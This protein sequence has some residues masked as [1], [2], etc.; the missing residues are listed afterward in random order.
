MAFAL[1]RTLVRAG[2]TERNATLGTLALV[3]SPMYLM[4]SATFMSD[5]TG[6]FGIVICLYGCLRA[7][8]S[9]TD[10]STLAW[11]GFAVLTNA[12]FGSSRQIAWLGILVMLPSTL[13]L[14]RARRRVFLVGA[15]F[16]LAGALFV[17]VCLH[18]LKHQPYIVP[19]HLNLHLISPLHILDELAYFSCDAPFLL[20]PALALFFPELRKLRPRVSMPLAALALGY[21]FLALYP[22]HLRGYFPLEP[23]GECINPLATFAFPILQGPPPPFLSLTLQALFTLLAFAGLVGLITRLC[24]SPRTTPAATSPASPSWHQL[25]VL[26]IPFCLAYTFLISFLGATLEFHDRYLLGLLLIAILCLFRYFQQQGLPR[27]PLASVL[28]IAIMAIY[29]TF[30]DHQMFAFYR[31]RV[32]LAAELTAAGVPPTAVDNGWEYNFGI[33]L[34]QADHINVPFIEWPPHA[35]VPTPQPTGA[36]P[37]NFGSFTPHIHPRYSVSFDPNACYGPAPFAPVHYS[38]WP[39]RT[40]GTL[41]VVRSTPPVTP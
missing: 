18:W 26:L 36:C 35:Y 11:L 13:W 5:I 38:R 21:C 20:I 1:H 41:Y 40:P 29:S 23:F 33:E 8:Q 6:L 9:I 17:L 15:A 25:G 31:A 37:M 24:R 19:E 3:L 22:S 2:L 16:N 32:A 10:R 34:Q 28:L 4:L 30:A 7:L 12:V 14:L 39:Y 27:L